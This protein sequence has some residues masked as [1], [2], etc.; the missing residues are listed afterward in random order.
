MNAERKE[1]IISK[2]ASAA[3]AAS[4]DAAMDNEQLVSKVLQTSHKAPAS[5][6]WGV[7][8]LAFVVIAGGVYLFWELRQAQQLI[9][10]QQRQMD[11]L[12][13]KILLSGDESTQSLTVLTANLKDIDKEV[14]KALSET[15]KLWEARNVNRDAIKKIEN[16]L[17]GTVADIKKGIQA[18]S[19]FE[20]TLASLERGSGEQEILLQSFRENVTH[21]DKKITSV[22]TQL[23]D[24]SR[25]V[26]AYDEAIRSFDKFRITT[27]RDLLL[28]KERNAIPNTQRP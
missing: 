18:Q 20:K 19:A 27:N 24:I 10:A 28:L 17:D 11:E 5:G 22:L 23:N 13:K 21:Q 15:D 3:S 2:G 16:V 26:S 8:L 7:V 14:K 25:K 6:L 9:A 12:E 1:P 4:L